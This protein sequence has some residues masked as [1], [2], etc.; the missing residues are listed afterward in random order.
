M[1]GRTVSR[2]NKTFLGA[3]PSWANACVGDN[4]NPSYGQYS[5]G[6]SQAANLL[7]NQVLNDSIQ[8]S[9]DEFV[10]PVCFNMRHSVELRLKGAIS[11]LQRLGMLVGKRLE[12]D[13]NGS[14]DIGKIWDYFKTQSE[15][16]DSRYQCINKKILPTIIDIA[17]I[18]ATGQTFRYPV[19]TESKKHLI[20]VGL[21]NFY[22]LKESFNSL[23]A[24]L[25]TLHALN[26][27]LIMEYEYKSFTKHLSRVQLFKM[28][29]ELPTIDEW[30]KD[31]FVTTKQ[32]L[33]ESF[34][35]SSRELSQAINIIKEN[36]ELAPLIGITIDLHG[37][38]RDDLFSLFTHWLSLHED[39]KEKTLAGATISSSESLNVFEHI[40]RSSKIKSDIWEDVSRFLTDEKLAGFQALFYFARDLNFSEQ[41][42]NTYEQLLLEA[43]AV[44]GQPQYFKQSFMH[45]LDKT[46]CFRNIIQSLYFLKH[47]ELARQLITYFNWI[48]VFE[49]QERAESREMFAKPLYSQYTVV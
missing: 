15:E 44:Q 47:G 30:Q 18:D 1:V 2:E 13:L 29:N 20:D 45:L 16:L 23:E 19:S 4:G 33:K 48:G 34:G 37:I 28:A 42:T 27:F 10:Y 36:Y 40:F 14:H 46:N 3:D 26:K 38:D 7:I 25:E 41:Y 6:F 49:W 32:S 5:M 22:I 9:V 12:F 39:A 24:H 43:K 17:A 31:Y 11:E 8:Y 21:I 35:I